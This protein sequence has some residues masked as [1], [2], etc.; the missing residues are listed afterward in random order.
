MKDFIKI[1]QSLRIEKNCVKLFI[2]IV[3]RKCLKSKLTKSSFLT[4]A[5]IT[6]YR[7]QNRV[8]Q[9]RNAWL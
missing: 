2:E 1:C 9:F 7:T 5:S 6:F 3:F 4:N 8:K